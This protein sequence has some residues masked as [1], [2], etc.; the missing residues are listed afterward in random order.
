MLRHV[1]MFKLRDDVG[2]AGRGEAISALRDLRDAIPEIQALTVAPSALDGG[3][4]Y[5]LV[6]EADFE[7]VDAFTRYVQHD[8]HVRAWES[9]VKP[10]TTDVASIQFDIGQM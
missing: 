2:D 7:N 9:C 1:V 5:D 3:A 4:G 8:S 6:L 10:M